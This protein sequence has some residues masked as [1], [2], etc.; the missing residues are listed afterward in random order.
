MLCRVGSW[1]LAIA[2]VFCAAALNRSSLLAVS[3]ASLT[4]VPQTMTE[5]RLRSRITMSLT[6]SLTMFR[7]SASALT[8]CQPGVSCQTIRPSSSQA[9]RKSGDC[10]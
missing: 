4:L 6:L 2:F 8:Y 10:G 5:G 3:W 7:Q 1:A 9:S